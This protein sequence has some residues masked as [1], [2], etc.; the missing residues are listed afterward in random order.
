MAGSGDR[1]YVAAGGALLRV[2]PGDGTVLLFRSDEPIR[3]VAAA[4]D[5]GIFFTTA[6]GVFFLREGGVSFRMLDEGAQDLQVRGDD[7]FLLFEGAGVV[8][9]SPVSSFAT[10]AGGRS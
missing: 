9:G 6:R 1:A 8:R 10:V 2:A 7:L 5:V 4:G 3:A